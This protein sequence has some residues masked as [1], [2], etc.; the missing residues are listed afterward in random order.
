MT[1][2][3]Y[4]EN[5]ALRLADHPSSRRRLYALAR[6]VYEDRQM[7]GSETMRIG[8]VGFDRLV[9]IARGAE[10]S[11]HDCDCLNTDRTLGM[12]RFISRVRSVP[13]IFVRHVESD[14][15]EAR[16]I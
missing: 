8:G 2:R 13:D 12:E 11:R 9:A 10:R 4:L 14:I 3:E 6:Q 1:I 16:L 15:S 5:Q 7:H